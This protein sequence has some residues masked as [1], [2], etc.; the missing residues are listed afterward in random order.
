MTNDEIVKLNQSYSE[1]IQYDPSWK[2]DSGFYISRKFAG[3]EDETRLPMSEWNFIKTVTVTAILVREIQN[4]DIN[5]GVTKVIFY[6]QPIRYTIEGKDSKEWFLKLETFKNPDD[7]FK[8]RIARVFLK[9]ADTGQANEAPLPNAL[10]DPSS[11]PFLCVEKLKAQRIKKT[12]LEAI[13]KNGLC[14]GFFSLELT[15]KIT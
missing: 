7:R 11:M 8:R 14:L 4:I 1:T 10:F 6:Q 13:F 2:E 9:N 15:N 3:S 12:E 5:Q